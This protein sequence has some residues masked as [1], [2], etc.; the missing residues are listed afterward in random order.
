MAQDR[1]AA[2]R[3]RTLLD[4]EE[5]GPRLARLR[6]ADERRVLD[7][8]EQN[9]GKEARAEI[10]AADERRRDRARIQE[11]ARLL[12][13]A[14]LNT[15]RQH[16]PHYGTTYDVAVQHL[17]TATSP[18]LRRVINADRQQLIDY[19]REPPTVMYPKD[20]NPFWYH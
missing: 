10:L 12:H 15:V 6:G 8:I 18:D 19:I 9:R 7:L 13:L 17:G 4:S 1:N 5:Y 20:N 16:G 11:R 14:A 3:L 2:A